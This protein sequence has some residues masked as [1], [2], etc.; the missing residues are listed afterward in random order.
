MARCSSTCDEMVRETHLR[1]DETSSW[2]EIRVGRPETRPVQTERSRLQRQRDAR[3]LYIMT[4]GRGTHG[5]RTAARHT[6]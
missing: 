5:A 6:V 2:R 3:S 1:A 4:R